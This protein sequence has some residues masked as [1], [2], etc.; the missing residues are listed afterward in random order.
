MVDAPKT[1]TIMKFTYERQPVESECT[2][3]ITRDDTMML[4]FR[5][6]QPG[7]R[8]SYSNFFE[9]RDFDFGMSIKESSAG[10]NSTDTG[11]FASW[12]SAA[13]EEWKTIA[14]KDYPLEFD[15]FSFKRTT[16]RASPL[17]FKN[18]CNSTTFDSATVVKRLSQGGDRP[19]MGVMRVD[20]YTVLITGIDWG[21][22][23]LIEESCDFICQ[24]MKITLRT[25]AVDGTIS[26]A[27]EVVINW[28]GGNIRTK[29]A[30]S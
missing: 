24:K 27:N 19:V 28:D 25:Q 17:L 2:L 4:G 15:K 10:S 3:A 18:C 16:D 12:R 30:S 6:A 29:Y 9:V 7:T 21:N 14:K 23:D 5:A 1:D 20:F 13:N 22:G 8:E 11:P 26:S